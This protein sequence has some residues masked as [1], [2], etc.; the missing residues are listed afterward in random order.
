MMFLTCY[1]NETK[2]IDSLNQQTSIIAYTERLDELEHPHKKNKLLGLDIK[3]K[4]NPMKLHMYIYA[5]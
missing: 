3:N 1:H 2:P 5:N 4:K